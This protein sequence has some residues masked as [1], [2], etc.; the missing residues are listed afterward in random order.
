MSQAWSAPG[1]Q[2][3]SGSI[4]GGEE[5][6]LLGTLDPH[7]FSG[8]GRR[9]GCIG[10]YLTDSFVFGE[11]AMQAGTLLQFCFLEGLVE[12]FFIISAF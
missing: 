4:L 10:G 7:S 2:A 11:E 12:Q 9:K 6:A 5:V 8:G 3:L 1:Q